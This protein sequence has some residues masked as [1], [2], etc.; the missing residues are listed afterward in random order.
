MCGPKWFNVKVVAQKGCNVR[1]DAMIDMTNHVSH[2][3]G[4]IL[5]AIEFT[6]LCTFICTTGC[7]EAQIKE[8]MLHKS[9]SFTYLPFEKCN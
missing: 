4:S 8:T 9:G 7:T 6:V 5:G 3:L 2:H 1:L